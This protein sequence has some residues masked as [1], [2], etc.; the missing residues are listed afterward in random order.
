MT[1]IAIEG[2]GLDKTKTDGLFIYHGWEALNASSNR[3]G[4]NALTVLPEGVSTRVNPYTGDVSINDLT[5]DVSASDRLAQLLMS[6]QRRA[7]YTLAAAITSS[8][9]TV[10]IGTTGLDSTVVWVG[11]ETI[12]LG[13]D[14][15]SGVYTGCTRGFWSSPAQAHVIDSGV[16]TRVPGW[17]DRMVT[18]I[19]HDP[20]DNTETVVGRYHI[21]DIMMDGPTVSITTSELLGAWRSAEVNGESENLAA[22]GASTFITPTGDIAGALVGYTAKVRASNTVQDR[23]FVEVNGD[24]VNTFIQRASAIQGGSNAGWLFQARREG[25]GEE[26]PITEMHE[27]FAVWRQSGSGSTVVGSFSTSDLTYPAH[28]L[29][30]ALALLSSTGQG[31]NGV[32]DVLG[33]SW[34]LGLDYISWASWTTEIN[35]HPD[36]CIDELVLGRGGESVNVF[37]VV[38]NQLLRPFGYFLSITTE[39]LITIE[40]LRLPT[41]IDWNG[42]QSSSIDAF[43]DGPLRMERAM[44]EISDRVVADVGGSGTGQ[45]TRVQVRTPERSSRR[46]KLGDAREHQLDYT[47]ISP[48]RL[49][50]VGNESSGALTN[51]LVNLLQLSLDAVPRLFIRVARPAVTGEANYN[52]G[53]IIRIN[54]LCNLQEAWIVDSSGTRVLDLSAIDFAGMII[55]RDYHLDNRTYT[56]ELLFL[57]YHV[58]QYVRLR[59]PSGVIESVNGAEATIRL[60]SDTFSDDDADTFTVDDEVEI[61]TVD[62]AEWPSSVLR[63]IDSI[64]GDDLVLSGWYA[65][66]PSAGMIVRLARSSDYSNTGLYSIT[67]RPYAYLADGSDQIDENGDTVEADIYGTNIYGGATNTTDGLGSGFIGIDEDSFDTTSSDCP[68]LD[69]WLEHRLRSNA[70][71]LI[72]QGNQI[73]WS[74]VSGQSNDIDSG[75]N[76]RPYASINRSTIMYV[77]WLIEPGLSS[78]E[79]HGLARVGDEGSINPGYLIDMELDSQQIPGKQSQPIT[80]TDTE[81]STP[82]T[83]PWSGTLTLSSAPRSREIAPLALWGKSIESDTSGS[84]SLGSGDVRGPVLYTDANFYAD[85]AATRP[86]TSALDT[87]FTLPG[88]GDAGMR[89]DHMQTVDYG[90]DEGM[91]TYPPPVAAGSVQKYYMSYMQLRGVEIHQKF[92]DTTSPAKSELVAQVPV[93]GEV[94]GMHSIRTNAVHN[95]ARPLWVGPVGQ[96]APSE[97][98]WPTGYVTRFAR[99]AG[100]ATD[101]AVITANVFP[102]T[103]NPKLM[104]MLYVLPTFDQTVYSG[105]LLT[106]L[107]GE[108]SIVGDWTVW[109]TVDELQTGETW[110]T[111]TSLGTSYDAP[112]GNDD[113]DLQLNHLPFDITGQLPALTTE[114]MVRSGIS[115]SNGFA[116]KEGQLFAPDLELLTLVTTDVS[117]TRDASGELPCRVKIHFDYD[118]RDTDNYFNNTDTDLDTGDAFITVVGASIWE[119]PQ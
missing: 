27:V 81:S 15:G 7:A 23:V 67:K 37:A 74:I 70:R 66:D 61:W 48:E 110:S 80:A 58:G 8:A 26:T 95:R 21:Q 2:V 79:V 117:I 73:S 63:T 38:Q 114:F 13:T 100:D 52:H 32:Y 83:R 11:D 104:C 41:L 34:G 65:S 59:A 54:D 53:R 1:G 111:A 72:E 3:Q 5:F 90:N 76:I 30:I 50:I 55:G 49:G 69:T 40:R 16:Y 118:T 35:A 106:D 64:S 84:A 91:A 86:N 62:G 20:N 89:M 87:M 39:G 96:A 29:A 88:T 60:E 108:E 82:E 56:L 18:L 25:D 12:L 33:E 17:E 28:P 24:G 31:Y 115:S 44:Q 45:T 77:P 119:I 92:E 46:S 71:H 43:I 14:S 93:V 107:A 97:D 22:Y 98:G 36:M 4:V 109:A 85:S 10:N 112:S 105:S 101:T 68:P 57:S 113:P 116:M 47:V 103:D 19:E 94:C 99:I 42:A 6:E 78:V 9:T 51:A 75:D 102:S